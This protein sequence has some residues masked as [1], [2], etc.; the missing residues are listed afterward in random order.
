MTPP[1][2]DPVT[3][4]AEHGSPT[5]DRSRP[6]VATVEP[7]AVAADQLLRRRA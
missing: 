2:C 3:I 1:A 5:F 7:G 4:G 6:P